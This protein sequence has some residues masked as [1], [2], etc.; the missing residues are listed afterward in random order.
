M[1]NTVSTTRTSTTHK[2]VVTAM[3]SAVAF[4]LM[5][6]EVPIPALIPSF[7]K[8]D[9]SDLPELLG[10][11][12]LG[13]VYGSIICLLKNLLHILIKGTSSGGAGELCNFLLG[14]FF[15]VPAGAL[16]Q[17]LKPKDTANMTRQEVKA[18]GL[19][20]AIIGSLVGT[21]VMAV[22]SVPLNYFVT[23][24]IYGGMELIIGAYQTILPSMK[25]LLQCL[26]VFNMPFTFVKGLLDVL[27]C[28][29]IYKPLS[30]LLHK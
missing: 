1:T 24:P 2:I 4:A 18:K 14:V 5:F 19:K 30:P 12:A 8:M 25:G 21:I 11:F 29:V 27:L 28:L 10:A 3:L 23:Y 16:Y 20:A 15:V 17:A 7:V 9:I 13:P 26:L 22:A 6:I